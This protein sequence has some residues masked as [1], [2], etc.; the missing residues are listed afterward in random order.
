MRK[1]VGKFERRREGEKERSEKRTRDENEER[2]RFGG[3]V[4]G[5]KRKEKE[6]RE[7]VG[8]VK[9]V[10]ELMVDQAECADVLVLNKCDLVSAEDIVRLEAILRGLNPR[11]EILRTEQGQIASEVLLDRVRFDEQATLGAARWIRVLQGAAEG[12]RD[13]GVASAAAVWKP[14]TARHEDEYGI[15]SF[16]FEA[17]RALVRE[18]FMAWL[19][20][21][22]PTGLLRAK[23][24]FWFAD[25]AADIGFL[26]V[27]G[28]GVRTEFV[29]TW[30]AA[31]VEAGV[32]TAAAVPA[33]A[34]EKWVEPQGDRRVELVFIGVGL[35]EAT[36]RV[37]LA[38]C[39][40]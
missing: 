31:L 35:D 13:G 30:A 7:R 19:A 26:S 5:R 34:R 38:R 17:R 15:R 8:G 25:Q 18:K 3:A 16:V 14:G 20:T 24:F 21:D 36:M 2:E 22:L 1:K 37:G 33:N 9:P 27:A 39:L 6:E 12:K 40:A 29:G 23:G 11:A 4:A 28:G 10:F 32:I